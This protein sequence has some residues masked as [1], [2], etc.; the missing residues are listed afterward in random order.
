MSIGMS[1][2]KFVKS[3]IYFYKISHIEV[4]IKNVGKCVEYV[5]TPDVPSQNKMT[6][7][8]SFN[9]GTN[10]NEIGKSS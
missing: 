9:K 3:W 1:L 5:F 7:I 10:T 6:V 8:D 4:C 2:K